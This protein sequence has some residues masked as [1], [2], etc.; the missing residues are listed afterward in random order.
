[1]DPE[2]VGEQL[3]RLARFKPDMLIGFPS[4]LHHF[5]RVIAGGARD[6]VKPRVMLASGETLYD[7]QRSPIEEAFDAPVY[8][9]YGCCEFGAVARECT[10]R[11]GLHIAAERVFIEALPVAQLPSGEEVCELVITGL[12]NYGMPFIRYAIEDLG[13]VT[14]EPCS[15]GLSLPRLTSLSGRVYD[16][17]QAPNGN[18]LGGT[19]WG[20]VL[21]EGVERF[22]VVQEKLDEITISLVP[23]GE[24]GETAKRYVL[25]KVRQACG[26]T[27]RVQFDVRQDLRMTPSGKH[28]YVISKIPVKK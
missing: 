11:D 26:E 22:Q 12:D 2:T 7:W 17:I 28:R 18:F 3:A 19:F 14:W 16:V 10:L 13:T 24:F 23:A 20:H 27:M 8:N 5:A 1:M 21:K 25:D 15:C 4:V 6:R 9:H